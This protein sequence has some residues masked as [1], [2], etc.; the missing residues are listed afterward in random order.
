VLDHRRKEIAASSNLCNLFAMHA[1]T[2][3]AQKFAVPA[4]FEVNGW[5][6]SQN[7]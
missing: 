2:F 3:L 7:C 5:I 6:A 4:K 1:G